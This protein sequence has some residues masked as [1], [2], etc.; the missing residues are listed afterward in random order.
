MG[1]RP[2]PRWGTVFERNNAWGLYRYLEACLSRRFYPGFLFDFAQDIDRAVGDTK[3][4]SPYLT[5]WLSE[6]QHLRL[7]GYRASS[8]SSALCG[9]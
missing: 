9:N 2:G 8:A 4:Y 7:Q 1:L 5:I 3:A 6:F